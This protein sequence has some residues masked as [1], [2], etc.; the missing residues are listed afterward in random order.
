MKKLIDLALIALECYLIFGSMMMYANV[1]LISVLQFILG[2]MLL[3]ANL[4]LFVK[5]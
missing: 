5:M 2:M 1:P 4:K 3:Y